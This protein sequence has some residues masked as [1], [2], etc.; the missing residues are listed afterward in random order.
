MIKHLYDVRES[1]DEYT[2]QYNQEDYARIA[3]NAFRALGIGVLLTGTDS[4]A[5]NL[6]DFELYSSRNE[7]LLR[8]PWC[9]VVGDLPGTDMRAL[10]IHPSFPRALRPFLEF[11]RPLFAQIFCAAYDRLIVGTPEVVRWPVWKVF[12]TLIQSACTEIVVANDLFA[13]EDG[14]YGQLRLLLGKAYSEYSKALIH[15]HFARI[16][17]HRNFF[18]SACCGEW[19][20]GSR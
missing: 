20:A 9:F 1:L 8:T 19:Y 16:V 2:I 7:N 6:I 11:S 3:R 17:G 14:R 15:K 13:N 4:K 10:N 5:V 12:D 18:I